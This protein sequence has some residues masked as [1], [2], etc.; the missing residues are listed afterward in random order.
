MEEKKRV[1]PLNGN[2]SG[3]FSIQWKKSSR[4]FHSMEVFWAD[5]PFNGKRAAHRKLQDCLVPYFVLRP[6][7]VNQPTKG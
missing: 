1:F 5:F 3:E 7:L 4:F 6:F 2:F